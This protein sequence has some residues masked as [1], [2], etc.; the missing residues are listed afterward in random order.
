MSNYKRVTNAGSGGSLQAY[1]HGAN[2]V[3]IKAVF[4][5]C[6]PGGYEDSEK[7]YDGIEYAF[8]NVK[9][10]EILRLYSRWGEWRVGGSNKETAEVF[11][12]WVTDLCS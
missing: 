2:S 6:D 1:V 12:L 4:G 3:K 10:G 8:K 11:A 5:K 7:G 9:T